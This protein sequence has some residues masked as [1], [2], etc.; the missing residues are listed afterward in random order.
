MANAPVPVTADI[1]IKVPVNLT[2][3]PRRH[4]DT[5]IFISIH[6]RYVMIHFLCRKLKKIITFEIFFKFDIHLLSTGTATTK[7]FDDGIPVAHF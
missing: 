4:T 1:N 6:L 7:K 5:F 2:L 3:E